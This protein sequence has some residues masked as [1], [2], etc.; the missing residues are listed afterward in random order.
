MATAASTL[1]VTIDATGSQSGAATVNAQLNS[2]VNQSITVNNTL[3]NM[4]RTSSTTTKK[5]ATDFA[6]LARYFKTFSK[7][8]I[9]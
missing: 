8:L 6:S 7:N 1:Y 5:M 2:I 9:F 3:I 4:G